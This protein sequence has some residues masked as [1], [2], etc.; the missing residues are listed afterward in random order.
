M[1]L[2]C[3]QARPL[4]AARDAGVATTVTSIDLERST[5]EVTL[6]EAGVR[7]DADA[8]PWELIERVAG[9]DS[10]CFEI[11]Q[12]QAERVQQMSQLSGRLASLYPTLGPPALLLSG[13]LMHRIKGI[14]SS[15]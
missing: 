10:G 4:L 3:V 12:G 9:D 5:M 7:I 6:A 14:A 8:L 2:S 11:V 1:L 15:L 13:V